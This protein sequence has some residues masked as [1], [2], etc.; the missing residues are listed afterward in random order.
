MDSV[1]VQYIE[2]NY[3]I[4]KQMRCNYANNLFKHLV[5][6]FECH[7]DPILVKTTI[8]ND[9]KYSPSFFKETDADHRWSSMA[10]QH[11]HTLSVVDYESRDY[12]DTEKVY[13]IL[14]CI[15]L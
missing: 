8:F 15:V 4:P 13:F 11:L 9:F 2:H 7:Y 12:C 6:L 14:Y 5:S 3:A 1:D 10:I